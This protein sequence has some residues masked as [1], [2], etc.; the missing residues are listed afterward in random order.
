MFHFEVGQIW[1]EVSVR[2]SNAGCYGPVTR[3]RLRAASS[4]RSGSLT[5]VR[6]SDSARCRGLLRWVRNP[7]GLGSEPWGRGFGTLA[8][9]FRTRT[10]AHGGH[11]NGFRGLRSGFGGLLAGSRHSG[12]RLSLTVPSPS[13]PTRRGS[14]GLEEAAEPCGESHVS[15]NQTFRG[16]ERVCDGTKS[17]FGTHEVSPPN[18]AYES[19]EPR[20]CG[21]AGTSP[22]PIAFVASSV[23]RRKGVAPVACG[24]GPEGVGP[25]DPWA[26]GRNPRAWAATALSWVRDGGPRGR[27]PFRSPRNPHAWVSRLSSRLPRSASARRSR[28]S[29]RF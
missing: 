14:A 13:D 25:G 4:R 12:A 17:G 21:S 9:G 20:T 2:F 18:P 19:T 22:G 15:G 24:F 10:A 29:R 28:S 23:G 5:A 16:L 8:S 3:S 7:R 27:G 1:K 11:K 6:N 26:K